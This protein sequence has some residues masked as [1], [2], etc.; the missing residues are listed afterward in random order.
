MNTNQVTNDEFTDNLKKFKYYLKPALFTVLAEN[1]DVF[2][3]DTKKEIV[4][5]LVEADE[6]VKDLHDY[7]EKRNGILKRG[8]EKIDDIY[9]KAKVRFQSAVGNHKAQESA[10][11]EQL[12]SNL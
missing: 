5:K 7:Q 1:A 10:D 8:L 11:A 3:D 12:L 2:S 4:E 6:Q 9:S